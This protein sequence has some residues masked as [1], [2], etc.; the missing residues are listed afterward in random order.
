MCYLRH[1]VCCFYVSMVFVTAETVVSRNGLVF[2]FI[3]T[4]YSEFELY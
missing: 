2:H 4:H 3:V 1:D